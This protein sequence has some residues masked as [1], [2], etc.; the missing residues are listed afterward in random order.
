MGI[1]S[2]FMPKSLESIIANATI[3][4][5]RPL[6][7]ILLRSEIALAEFTELAKRAYVEVAY[8]HF[9]IPGKKMT[10]SRV[11]VLTGLSR[12]EVVRLANNRSEDEAPL[13][14][15]PN[16]AIRVVNGWLNDLEFLDENM[17]PKALPLRGEHASF[18]TLVA[19][20]SGDITLG[21]VLDELQ[22]IGV[23]SKPDPHSVVLTSYGFVPQTGDSEKFDILSVCATD[24][25]DTGLHNLDHGASQPRLQRQVVHENVPLDLAR[26]FQHYSD[27]KIIA[28]LHDLNRFLRDGKNQIKNKV[29]Q[30]NVRI[31]V[32]I[33]Y[34]E[35]ENSKNI[36]DH[37]NENTTK[38]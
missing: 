9:S 7:R 27:E 26:A 19:R 1:K 17:Q 32:G 18:T 35:N 5:L 11:A 36:E 22:R 6:V 34:F 10:Y 37:T 16:R 12:K 25:L 8:K 14:T 21:A 28:L 15:T 31:G 13:R 3:R 4:I 38:D 23:V 30:P 29:D 33:Y 20:Y 2:H 24:L